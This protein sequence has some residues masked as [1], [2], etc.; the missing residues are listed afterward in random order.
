MTLWWWW[1]WWWWYC[2]KDE[3]RYC[4][5]KMVLV[6]ILKDAIPDFLQYTLWA[7][8]VSTGTLLW[9]W[10]TISVDYVQYIVVQRDSLPISLDRAEIAFLFSFSFGWNQ[11]PLTGREETW[12]YNKNPQS[13]ENATYLAWNSRQKICH[14]VRL[15]S[16]HQSSCF[17][18]HHNEFHVCPN[19]VMDITA[20]D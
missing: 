8:I 13:W 2:N 16:H 17:F 20:C 15:S 10:S 7:T 4:N 18:F 9:Q 19:A 12:V 11:S 14:D 6:M 1:W 5:E 3:N